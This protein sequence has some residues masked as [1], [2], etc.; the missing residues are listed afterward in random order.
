MMFP[1][2]VRLGLWLAQ[3]GGWTEAA[4]TVV[5]QPDPRVVEE[6]DGLKEQVAK[7]AELL[8]VKD[9]KLQMREVAVKAAQDVA[10]KLEADLA[11]ARTAA[12]R[13]IAPS[14]DDATLERVKALVA[15][16]ADQSMSGEAK[17]HQVYARLLKEYPAASK[18]DLGLAIEV[19]LI[20]PP[21]EG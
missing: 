20:E 5:T 13:A 7:L 11:V 10:A 16:Y 17:R 18:R 14:L 12:A 8:H 9:V 6:R 19:A 1:W 3:K 21:K 15:S 2:Y 4:P